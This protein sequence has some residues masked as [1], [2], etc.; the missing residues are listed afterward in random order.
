MKK[1]L[2]I[3]L[4]TLFPA[5]LFAQETVYSIIEIKRENSFYEEQFQLWKA[6]TKKNPKNVEAWGN[7]YRAARYN[8]FPAALREEAAREE[9]AKIVEDMLK[10]IPNTYE[11]YEIAAWN[12]PFGKEKYNYLKKAYAIDP[13]QPRILEGMFSYNYRKGNWKEAHKNMNDWYETGAMAPQLLQ[14]CNNFLACI[15]KNGVFIT[16]GDNDSYPTWMLQIAQ[17][18]RP[19]VAVINASILMDIDFARKVLALYDLKVDESA[20]D[21]LGLDQPDSY[22]RMG[23][24]IKHLA[25]KNP[26]RKVYLPIACNRDL[27]ESLSGRLYVVGTVNQFNPKHFDYMALLKR[28]W[29][30]KVQLQYLDFTPY[31]TKYNYSAAG[32]P[33][34]VLHYFYPIFILYRHYTEAGESQNATEMLE[35]GKKLSVKIG[36]PDEYKRFLEDVQK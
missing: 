23:L 25:E 18:V 11:A 33:S 29:H 26:D 3:L 8:N 36:N 14:Y 13:S 20:Y 12:A 24:F 34:T 28:N 10:A 31:S 15:E 7:L 1:K 17:N 16:Q 21:Y 6:E 35:L 19:D 27:Y 5:I 9:L 30:N 22:E 32:L 4:L 2:Y